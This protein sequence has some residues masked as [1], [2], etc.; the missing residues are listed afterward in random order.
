MV[1]QVPQDGKN[2]SGHMFIGLIVELQATVVAVGNSAPMKSLLKILCLSLFNVHYCLAA[3]LYLVMFIYSSTTA[4][5]P[6]SSW[7]NLFVSPI[8]LDSLIHLSLGS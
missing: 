1:L 2:F 6:F 3:F 4:F 7:V 8:R 5:P